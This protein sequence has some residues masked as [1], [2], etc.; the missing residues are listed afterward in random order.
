M[1]QLAWGEKPP[2]KPEERFRWLEPAD[3]ALFC[4]L[5]DSFVKI[6]GSDE[7]EQ[8]RRAIM[9]QLPG[10]APIFAEGKCANC[11]I[12]KTVAQTLT[13]DEFWKLSLFSTPCQAYR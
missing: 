11:E 1:V 2:T 4:E 3:R 12:R 8:Y 13:P 9:S 5:R 6:Y 7:F 10:E